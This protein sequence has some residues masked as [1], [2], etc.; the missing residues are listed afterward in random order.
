MAD[1]NKAQIALLGYGQTNKAILEANTQINFDVFDDSFEEAFSDKH[2]NKF[3]PSDKYNS[4]NNYKKQIITPGIPPHNNLA[5][6]SKNLTSDYDYFRNDFAFSIWISG[7]N[8]KTTLTQM[9]Y[10]LLGEKIS[11]M[12]GNIGI[13]LACMDK[14]KP[15][16]ILE[17]SSF[18]LHYTK[19][20]YPNI[21]LLLPINPDHISWHSSFE[22]YEKSKLKPLSLMDKTSIAIIPKCY[23]NI[24]TDAKV[25]YYED[26]KDLAN[27][28]QIDIEKI[29]IKQPFTI[30]AVLA[31]CV[32]KILFDKTCITTCNTFKIDP[33][34]LEEIQDSKN[35]T[36]VNDSKATNISSSMEAVKRY[37]NKKIHLILGGDSKKV[38]LEGLIKFMC[39]F[40][41]QIY[42]IGNSANELE[43]L[44]NKYD[45]NCENMQNM[46]NAVIK[47]DKTLQKNEIA[48]LSPSCASFDQFDSYKHRGEIFKSLVFDL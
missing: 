41:V 39:D 42:A 48:I 45:V 37:K 8:G 47:I 2:G 20:I 10:H 30:S 18:T 46:Q 4:S 28:M 1:K 17:T 15:V 16:W 5:K 19:H 43:K 44:A 7:T 34:K 36:W 27:K 33:H 12:G 31:L 3:Y 38:S 25:I 32:Q 14:N 9:I 24:P 11:Q 6:K 21:Y 35:R 22:E 29:T 13:P 23:S 40:D 26:E